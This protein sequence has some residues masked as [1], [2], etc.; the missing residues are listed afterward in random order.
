MAEKR[1]DSILEQTADAVPPPPRKH[2][3]ADALR[4]LRK[5][6]LSAKFGLLVIVFYVILAVFAPVLTPFGESEI[7]AAEYEPWGVEV[8][9]A[10][11]DGVTRSHRLLFGTDNLGRDMLTRLV[12][13]ARN[14]IGIAFAHRPS[15]KLAHFGNTR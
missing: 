3:A 5:A 12:Y 2:R 6:P 7:V 10:D 13:G 1:D 11:A 8:E 9:H 15:S 14:T 4:A